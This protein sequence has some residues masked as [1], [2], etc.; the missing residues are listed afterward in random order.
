MRVWGK[1]VDKISILCLQVRI[2]LSKAFLFEKDSKIVF[3]YL[4]I[5]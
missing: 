3:I 1:R 2:L 4:L 5:K